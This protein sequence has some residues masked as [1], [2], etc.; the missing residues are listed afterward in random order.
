MVILGQRVKVSNDDA[1]DWCMKIIDDGK[2]PNNP[3]G[4]GTPGNVQQKLGALID[5]SPLDRDLAAA[6]AA[7]DRLY[8]SS[9][10]AGSV[11]EARPYNDA[12]LAIGR[13]LVSVLYS[14]TGTYRQDPADHFK[15]LPE[16]AAAAEAV[17]TVPDGVLRT[18][19]TRSSNRLRRALGDATG[20]AES[21]TGSSA[22]G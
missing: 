13:A 10:R 14:R 2:E 18:E 19:L 7:V 20:A 15:L 1:R 21:V 12:L 8:A 5:W 3:L 11:P 17:G 4:S 6:Q 9:S 16:L 22:A